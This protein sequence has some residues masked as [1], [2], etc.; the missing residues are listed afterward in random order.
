MPLNVANHLCFFGTGFW[1]YWALI[2]RVLL[3]NL[4]E[5][6][7]VAIFLIMNFD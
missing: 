2:V 3:A 5:L 6:F 1:F 4:G 7:G